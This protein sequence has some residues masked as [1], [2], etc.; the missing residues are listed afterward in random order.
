MSIFT[1]NDLGKW[2]KMVYEFEEKLDNRSTKY[3]YSGI[4]NN[5]QYLTIENGS[6]D[7]MDFRIPG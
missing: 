3:S 1:T 6:R 2:F 7:V 5:E 4:Y